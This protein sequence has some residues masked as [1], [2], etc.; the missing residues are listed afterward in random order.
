MSDVSLKERIITNEDI[1]REECSIK[2]HMLS[3][4]CCGKVFGVKKQGSFYK[5]DLD[6]DVC[7]KERHLW[8]CLR[9]GKDVELEG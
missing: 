9:C 6:M 3:C 5:R 2:G 8:H 7:S 4:L 1:D